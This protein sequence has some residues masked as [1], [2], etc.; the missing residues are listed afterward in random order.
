MGPGEGLCARGGGGWEGRGTFWGLFLTGSVFETKTGGSAGD[1]GPKRETKVNI[2]EKCGRVEGVWTHLS[3]KTE[4]ETTAEKA[5]NRT[6][7]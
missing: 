2:K 4:R 6:F 5:Q 1:F 3:H 7:A